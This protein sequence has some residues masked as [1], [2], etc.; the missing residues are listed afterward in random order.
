MSKEAGTVPYFDARPAWTELQAELEAAWRRVMDSGWY[1]LG[2]E[3]ERFE[4]EFAAFCEARFCAGCGNGLDALR[5]ILEGYGIGPGDEVVVP[6]HTFVATWLAILQTGAKPVAVDVRPGSFN[7]DP[8]GIAAAVSA[9][10]R[11]IVV[12]HMY[13]QPA[14]MERIRAIAE[15]HALPIIEDAA[16][17]HGAR[18]NGRRV[19]SLGDAAAFSFYPA[20]NLGAFGDGGA[21]VSNDERLIRRIRKL[22]NYGSEIKYVHDLKGGNSR[23]DPLQAAFLRVRLARLDEWNARRAAIAARYRAELTGCCALPETDAGTDPV[24]HVFAVLHR[25]RERLG[26]HLEG[27][28]IQTQRHYPVP[29]HL[30]GACAEAGYRRGE[31]PGAEEIAETELSLPI[32]PH[33]PAEHVDRVIAAVRSFS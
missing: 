29:P 18:R 13:G 5:L 24:W 30:S 26:R 32:G 31:M 7:A 28:G 9:R 20:K 8:E 12:V 3:M 4:A 27:H 10:T 21:V 17:A 19:G 23:L 1:I 6:A 2:N 11:A 14:E 25:E 15:R 33:M 16:Q 22:R